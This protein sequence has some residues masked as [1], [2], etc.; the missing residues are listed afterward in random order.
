MNENMPAGTK[1]AV[2]FFKSRLRIIKVFDHGIHGYERKFSVAEREGLHR[3]QYQMVRGLVKRFRVTVHVDTD[4][5][6][7]GKFLDGVI[8]AAAAVEPARPASG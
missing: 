7:C 2:N 8:Y 1:Y 6:I 5:Q 4:G 3:Y